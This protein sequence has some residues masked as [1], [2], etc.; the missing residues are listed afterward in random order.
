VEIGAGGVGVGPSGWSPEVATP[1]GLVVLHCTLGDRVAGPPHDLVH[2]KTEGWVARWCWPETAQLRLAAA[3]IVPP[4][5]AHF[6][7]LDGYWGVVWS[8]QALGALESVTISAILAA[9]PEDAAGGGDTG[10]LLATVTYETADMTLS[11]GGHDEEALL[12]RASHHDAPQWGGPL[13]S[14]WATQLLPLWEAPF[15][16]DLHHQHVLV[17]RL[18]GLHPGERVDLHIAIA[19]GRRRDDAATWYAV[20]TTP[21]GILSQTLPAT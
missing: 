8:V 20:D 11:I 17:Y 19:W 5:D 1:F 12:A 3:R 4:L 14:R 10:E 6:E 13:P 2:P 18:P 21:E 15:G 9:L 16:V 7:P